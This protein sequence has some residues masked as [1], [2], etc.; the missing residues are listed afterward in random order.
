M[1]ISVEDIDRVRE[2][3][4]HAK[5]LADRFVDYVLLQKRAT[6]RMQFDARMREADFVRLGFRLAS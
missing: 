6:K 5:V 2:D 1:N 4:T 3:P